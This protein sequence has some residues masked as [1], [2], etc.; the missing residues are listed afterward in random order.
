MNTV[1]DNAI[2]IKPGVQFNGEF[3]LKDYAPMFRKKVVLD[4]ID[5]AKLYVCGLGYGYYY[6]NGK[7]YLMIYLLLR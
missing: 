1:F 7:K 3:A 2:F 6:I 5:N 4:N